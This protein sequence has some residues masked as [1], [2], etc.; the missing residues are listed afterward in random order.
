MIDE[1]FRAFILDEYPT[2]NIQQNT[3]IQSLDEPRIWFQRRSSE[4]D[5]MLNDLGLV[6]STFDVEVISSDIET[7][8]NITQDL[9]TLLHGYKGSFGDSTA[10][11]VEW[12]DHDD[13][14]IYNGIGDGDE[15]KHISSLQ[16]AVIHTGN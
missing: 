10:L 5:L 13:D 11:L 3:N 15:G 9:K 16:V 8:A 6:T 2:L 7:G 14:Y 1:D 12:T 4:Q